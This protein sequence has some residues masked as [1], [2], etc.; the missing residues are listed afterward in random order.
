[1][2][3]LPLMLVPAF[4]FAILHF[5]YISGPRPSEPRKNYINLKEVASK[6]SIFG[7]IKDPISQLR[8]LPSE[9]ETLN[10]S[11]CPE[12]KEISALPPNLKNL[13]LRNCSN[14]TKL[15]K[16]PDTLEHLDLSGCTSLKDF[17]DVLPANLKHL[18]A[19]YVPMKR[20]PVLPSGLQWL[21]LQGC[22]DLVQEPETYPESLHRISLVDTPLRGHAKGPLPSG[23]S[24]RALNKRG[25]ASTI[26]P[27]PISSACGGVF[28]SP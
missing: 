3:P 5:L 11:F 4:T 2:N 8:S 13:S 12:I 21:D 24:L 17:P 26:V 28:V 22:S 16:L 6:R 20:L 18:T 14:L 19:S 1:M 25:W 9:L 23:L 27:V 7:S 10:G 15:C